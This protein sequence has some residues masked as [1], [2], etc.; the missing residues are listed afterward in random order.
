MLARA[1]R[2]TEN[3]AIL[4]VLLASSAALNLSARAQRRRRSRS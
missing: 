4:S 1:L 2:V 3:V